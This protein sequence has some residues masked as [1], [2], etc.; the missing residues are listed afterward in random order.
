[1]YRVVTDIKFSVIIPLYN[2]ENSIQ[3][4]IQSVL[5]QTYANFELIV[6]NDGSTDNS[7]KVVQQF[8]DERINVLDK[9]NGGVSSARNL[10]IQS[11]KNQWIALLDGDDLWLPGFLEKM[12]SMIRA[13]PDADIH[14][15]EWNYED[16]SYEFPYK[17]EGYI[18]NYFEVCLR[19][20]VLSSSSIVIKSSCFEVVGYF[21]ECLT[22]GEDQ[23]MW[24]RLSRRFNI[25][26]SPVSLA[27]YRVM[28]ENRACEN[29]KMDV[30]KHF[31][32]E[33]SLQNTESPYEKRY[34]R[35]VIRDCMMHCIKYEGKQQIFMLM[36]KHGKG[37]ILYD[38]FL[39]QINRVLNLFGIKQ[40]A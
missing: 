31:A 26:F 8:S 40:L 10:G 37:E 24:S 22:N 6:V 35:K 15:V 23:E 9:K 14:S 4:T 39:L 3:S 1:M 2:K 38:L 11:A 17:T 27:I 30:K 33:L 36:Q 13:F 29:R 28:T 25:A 34:Y 19:G 5:D 18:P 20:A 7:L 32:Y 12:S 21:N 16:G